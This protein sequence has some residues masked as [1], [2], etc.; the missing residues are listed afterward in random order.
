MR[1]PLKKPP[2]KFHIDPRADHI[3]A[4]ILLAVKQA[5]MADMAPMRLD[6]E[7]RV[8]LITDTDFRLEQDAR[9]KVGA[10]AFAIVTQLWPVM[11]GQADAGPHI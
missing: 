4:G 7:A 6:A 1:G 2:S 8:N 5:R 3:E 11:D 9:A 10:A